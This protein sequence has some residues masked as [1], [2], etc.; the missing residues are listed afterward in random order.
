[1]FYNY[2]IVNNNGEDILYLYLSYR[3]EFSNEL[4]NHD[5]NDLE[6]RV[7]NFI[8][9]NSIPYKGNKVYLVVN[10]VVVK[11]LSIHNK[12]ITTYL[13]NDYSPDNFIIIINM[14][15]HAK[16]EI[17]LRDFLLSVLLSYYDFTLS[18]EVLKAICVLYNSYSFKMMNDYKE[19]NEE[20][21]FFDYQY[22]S[23]YKEK[24]ANYDEI[25]IY[26]N[27]IIDEMSGYFLK[28]QDDYILPFIHYSNSGK[29]LTNIKYKY[30]SSVKSIWDLLSDE[31]VH[32]KD[33]TYDEINNLLKVNINSKSKIEIKRNK[34][35]SLLCLDNK[36]FSFEEIKDRFNLS[37]MDFY[38]VIYNNFIRIISLG[39]GNGYGLSIFGANE[40]ALNGGRYNNILT[41]YFPKAK[42]YRYIK[43]LV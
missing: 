24:Y 38:F 6:R 15:D 23:Y 28:Y 39:K 10:G 34:T 16:Y 27:S 26:L 21:V 2:E 22:N 30:L 8:K 7:N 9:M 43:E 41:Y 31:L 32:Y 36:I 3:Y 13:V 29:T 17:T 11:A 19:I 4:I 1:M 37:S 20:N 18:I 14:K 42:I 33:F 35:N 25:I 40:I 5:I 12:K